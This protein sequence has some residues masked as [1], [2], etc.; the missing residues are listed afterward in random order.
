M[1]TEVIVVGRRNFMVFRRHEKS[2]ILVPLEKGLA[3]AESLL[4]V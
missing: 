2:G 3:F 1:V 4:A